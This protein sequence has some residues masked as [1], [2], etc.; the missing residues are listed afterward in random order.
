MKNGLVLLLLLV[1]CVSNVWSQD[2]KDS[3]IPLIGENAPSFTAETTEGTVEFPKDF[4]NKWKIIFSHPR[5]FTPVCSSEI[6]ELAH[7]QKEFDDIGV[8]LIVVSTDD[9]QQ[10]KNWKKALEDISYKDRNPVKIDFPFVDDKST[11]VSRKYG[12]I[13]EQTST[14]KDVR[15]VFII[16]PK[17]KVEAV[18]FYPM[19]IGR[20]MDEI[21]RTVVA[22]QTAG[23]GKDHLLTPANWQAG[24]DL[25]VPYYPYTEKQAQ[26]NPAIKDNYYEIGGFMWFKKA[27]PSLSGL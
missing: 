16:N 2:K 7:M 20:N 27:N 13:H 9:L 5:D 25:M 22:M 4:G 11:V 1:F 12:M 15:G 26:E 23:K 6:L 3:R 10:H 18:F 24:D 19:N 17:D 14:T 21:K 8:K